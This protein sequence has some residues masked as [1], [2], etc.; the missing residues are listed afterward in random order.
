M[1]ECNVCKKKFSTK[2]A[3]LQHAQALHHK[4]FDCPFCQKRFTTRNSLRQHMKDTNHRKLIHKQTQQI[5]IDKKQEKIS[6]FKTREYS[7]TQSCEH[8]FVWENV[9]EDQ[10]Y[11]RCTKCGKTRLEIEHNIK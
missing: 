6:Q 9:R 7:S 10:G 8:K 2:S 1:H 5:N 3:L 11:E 4:Q